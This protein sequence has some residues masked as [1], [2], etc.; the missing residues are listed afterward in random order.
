MMLV[1][2]RDLDQTCDADITEGAC[3]RCGQSAYMHITK[4]ALS[5]ARQEIE[6]LTTLRGYFIHGINGL[7]S[8]WQSRYSEA[9]WD[10]GPEGPSV[11]NRCAMDLA[12][13]SISAPYGPVA[14]PE[15]RTP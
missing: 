11:A 10:G 13:L 8:K 14:S 15:G 3:L 4:A 9:N 1:W 7:L 12:L 2:Q 6:R 5:S